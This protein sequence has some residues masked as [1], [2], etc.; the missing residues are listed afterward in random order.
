MS[1]LPKVL[2]A[3]RYKCV[4]DVRFIGHLYLLSAFLCSTDCREEL[5]GRQSAS[6]VGKG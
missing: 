2:T 5:A 6:P 3:V 4:A 1:S